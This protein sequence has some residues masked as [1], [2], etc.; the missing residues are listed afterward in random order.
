MLI[1][2]D[3]RNV[4]FSNGNVRIECTA[5]R[6]DGETVKIDD[7]VIPGNRYGHIVETLRRAFQELLEQ[8]G[9]RQEGEREAGEA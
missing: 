8:A 4:T 1:I 7:L 5:T 3:V 2:D 9:E 6:G